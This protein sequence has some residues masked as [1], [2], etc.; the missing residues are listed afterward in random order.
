MST[1]RTILQQKRLPLLNQFLRSALLNYCPD[2]R[3][4][5]ELHDVP[6]QSVFNELV[7]GH[8]PYGFG[9]VPES[10]EFRQ[11]GNNPPE[12]NTPY[13]SNQLLN[14]LFYTYNR[15]RTA[16][17]DYGDTLLYLGL[18]MLRSGDARQ[19]GV[20]SAPLFM[21]PVVL[22]R[23]DALSPFYLKAEG[24]DPVLNPALRLILQ[25]DHGI[26]LPQWN[27][28]QAD[29]MV[30]CLDYI[31]RSVEGKSGWHVERSQGCLDFFDLGSV[32]QYFDLDPQ[33]HVSNDFENHPTLAGI[34]H[35][36]F[37]HD[38][39]L[40]E[41]GLSTDMLAEPGEMVHALDANNEQLMVLFHAM[42]GG[43]LAVDGPAGTGKTQTIAN[44]ISDALSRNKRVLVVSSK[45]TALRD[46]KKR[47]S[48][49]G[50]SQFVLPLYGRHLTRSAVAKELQ[51]L[52]APA[53]FKKPE[54]VSLETLVR[55]RNKLN[56]YC[57]SI[58]TPIRDTGVS[59]YEAY[60]QLGELAA[61]TEGTNMP[62]YDGTQFV[63]WKK[64]EFDAF[65]EEVRR[66]QVQFVRIGVAQRHPFW[67][68]RKTVYNAALKSEIQQ[69]SRKAGMALKTLRA[70][71]AD[72]A[73]QMAAR[74]PSNSDDVIRLI[75]SASRALEAPDVHGISVHNEKWESSMMDLAAV[76]ETGAKLAAI[77]EK[78]D[79]I[80]IPEAWTQDVFQIRQSLVAHGS[81][82][83][84]LLIGDYRKAKDKLAG[85]CRESL[86]KDNAEQ[87][88]LVNGI[89]EVQRLQQ[90]LD[91]Y[92]NLA[93]ELF[94]RQWQGVQSNWEHLDKVSSWL[95]RLHQE[96]EERVIVSEVMEFIVKYPN[97]D[98]LRKIAEKVARDFNAFLE[99]SSV[100]AQDVGMQEALGISKPSF[101]RMPFG[102]LLSL[103]AHW[104]KH[105]DSLQDI[106]AFNHVAIR[107]SEKGMEDIV[108]IAVSWSES[109]RF[110]THCIEAA[111][112]KALLTDVLKTRRSLS[113][114]DEEAHEQD[115]EHF[116]RIDEQ[117]I[118]V[119]ADQVHGTQ[120]ER[121]TTNR[122]PSKVYRALVFELEEPPR[123]TLGE[124]IA[125]AGKSVQDMKP[126]F[127]MTPSSLAGLLTKSNVQFDL[128][129]FDEAE[130]LSVTDALGSISR[131]SQVIAFGDTRKTGRRVFWDHVGIKNSNETYVP[132]DA[133]NLLTTLRQRGAIEHRFTWQC[134]VRA[135]LQ[136][137]RQNRNVLDGELLIF[138]EVSLA[139]MLHSARIHDLSHTRQHQ[140]G[141]AIRS[142][143]S[144]LVSMIVKQVKEVPNRSVG[145]VLPGIEE[146]EAVEWELERRRRKDPQ[147]DKIIHGERHEPLM[148][149]LIDQ[150]QGEARDVVF[151]GLPFRSSRRIK[152]GGRM[153]AFQLEED[154]RRQI[155]GL[156]SLARQTVHYIVDAS[157]EEMSQW[158]EHDT[159]VNEWMR[160]LV[161]LKD[162]KKFKPWSSNALAYQQVLATALNEKGYK[163][164]LHLGSSEAHIDIA[165]EDPRR[166]GRFI[167]G[168]LGDGFPYKY[169]PTV[170]DRDRLQPVI[171]RKNGWNLYRL[172]SI[173]W[174]RNP[175]REI[176]RIC[177]HLEALLAD[178]PIQ[179]N[180]LSVPATTNHHQN[181]LS[182][183]VESD[184][185]QS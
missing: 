66:L 176:E 85:L 185:S 140:N 107:L 175:H 93:E 75:R 117:H 11:Q 155:H 147:L 109:A 111:R 164:I 99:A 37:V 181:G 51:R 78:Y 156:A 53:S 74:A 79:T 163:T 98:R 153:D 8:V 149:K 95:I 10:G 15:S 44:L 150:A 20:L 5:L 58:H 180:P 63:Q 94:G 31:A 25:R 161:D 64:D 135:A 33:N 103:F 29:G 129:I 23:K 97:L 145:I 34:L 179:T 42:H 172:W 118:A 96:I 173:E 61:A 162:V 119:M 21:V 62:G 133:D 9:A 182:S 59:P 183:S 132:V 130:R 113:S 22:E 128:V 80:L 112:Y 138:P 136:V 28:Y 100:A 43:N 146:L 12:V 70:S 151:V 6:L 170:R 139:R 86:P 72:L 82:K 67:G 120:V 65:L 27:V 143:V 48:T 30:R 110:L 76:M 38:I 69:N 122:L 39:V 49:V 106:V 1:V 17:E 90:K 137:H 178:S 88:K 46:I 154:I 24:G 52:K 121:F 126:V 19:V 32:Y 102:S 87:L 4:G 91:Q 57:N 144:E 108:K 18:G 177:S 7:V 104:E 16:L 55:V 40:N 114:F 47:L 26:E 115:I 2:G 165:V 71:S 3:Y 160:Y 123:R 83:T 73:H 141:K 56:I 116:T 92:T 158:A 171:L 84:R 54:E 166:K 105:I 81:K 168:I 169:A 127:M 125:D 41:E 14:R 159:A 157:I 50:L 77:R 45:T 134:E 142:L 60:V 167:L 124:L 148:V 36:G 152:S 101:G 184:V 13:T 68:S 174:F 89:L 35:Q 131:S